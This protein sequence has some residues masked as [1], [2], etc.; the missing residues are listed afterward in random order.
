MW[1]ALLRAMSGRKRKLRGSYPLIH[2]RGQTSVGCVNRTLMLMSL[3]QE[4]G[5]KY[6]LNAVQFSL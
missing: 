3:H 1:Y 6:V 4:K 5:S 2:D